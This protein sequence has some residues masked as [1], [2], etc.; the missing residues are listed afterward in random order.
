MP[1]NPTSKRSVP[2]RMAKAAERDRMEARLQQASVELSEGQH[3]SIRKAAAAHNVAEATLRHQIAGRCSKCSARDDLQALTPAAETALVDHI[4]R[5]A[6]SRYPL[7]P[8]ILRHY[9]TT[10][11]R[12]DTSRS[13][14]TKLSANWLQ[15]F[16]IR[17]PSIR[18]HWSR[19]LDNDRLSAA[20]EDTIRRW[21][22]QLRV[23]MREYSVASTNVFNV[24]ETGFMLGVLGTERIVVPAGDPSCRF[25]AQPGSWE[26][27]TVVECIGSG[28][29]VLPPLII[30]KGQRHV[31][32]DYRQMEGVPSLWNF[33]KSP[34]GWSNDELAVEWLETIFD[35]GTR[36]STPSPW[37]LLIING[38]RSHTTTPFIA[39]AWSK[40]ADA[41][42]H[43]DAINRSDFATFYAQARKKVMTQTRVRK[44]FSDSGITLDPTPQKALSRLA[45]SSAAEGRSETPVRRPLQ[46]IAALQTALAFNAAIDAHRQEPD[47]NEACNL[48]RV[49]L[50]AHEASQA[51]ISVLEAEI[52]VLRAHHNRSNK[53]AKTLGKKRV[54]GDTRVLTTNRIITR[55]YAERELVAK[56][57]EF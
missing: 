32:G 48:K 27:A 51:S 34:N 33:T 30:T 25:K 52:L 41:A 13:T 18:T 5:C 35:P 53:T 57:V 20:N 56:G 31:V 24:D 49:I 17:H 40:L 22:T 43:V 21:Y 16:L 50:E 47:S 2:S 23:I 26:W 42:E 54:Q 46:P 10:I 29:Q 28:G 19:C 36:P 7:T 3:D 45:G 1:R 37:R 8:S 12:T 44:A 11:T 38:H 39:S 55:E 6:C 15:S 9:A 4:R 14:T